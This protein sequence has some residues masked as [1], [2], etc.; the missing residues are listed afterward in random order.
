MIRVRYATN[1]A[2]TN[3]ATNDCEHT[4]YL[5]TTN[6]TENY[7]RC[8]KQWAVIGSKYL[9][10]QLAKWQVWEQLATD[11]FD[12]WQVV[13]GQIFT[14][15]SRLFI[16]TVFVVICCVVCLVVNGAVNIICRELRRPIMRNVA[17]LK[18][19]ANCAAY[20][21]RYLQ[22]D[23]ILQ[24]RIWTKNTRHFLP[25]FTNSDSG[26]LFRMKT[27]DFIGGW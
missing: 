18:I 6:A 27:F 25:Q 22:S 12:P 11:Q 17:C 20:T 5:E 7:K 9:W 16:S 2:Q 14:P 15:Y 13:S 26:E 24:F 10:E 8:R 23:Q 21:F 19:H 1:W 4:G 3:V